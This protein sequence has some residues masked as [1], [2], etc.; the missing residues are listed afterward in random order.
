MTEKKVEKKE[1]EEI[2]KWYKNTETG[3]AVL[4]V[5]YSEALTLFQ[6]KKED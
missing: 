4:A 2:K 5:D 6:V 1:A 3:E